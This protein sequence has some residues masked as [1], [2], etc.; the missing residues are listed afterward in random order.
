MLTKIFLRILHKIYIFIYPN[1]DI[2]GRNW[3]MFSHKEYANELIYQLLVNDKPAMIARFG[4]TEMICLVNYLGV[5]RQNTKWIDFIKDNSTQWWWDPKIINQMQVWSGFFPQDINKI[6]Q[7]CDLM[8]AD[9]EEVDILGSWLHDERHFEPSL[10]NAKRIVLE[11]LEPFFCANP[12]TRALEGKKVLVV[13][14]FAET[15]ENQYKNRDLIFDNH[16][17]PAFELKTIKAVQSVAGA[18]TEFADWFEA[19][20]S[21]KSQIDKTDYD[22]CIIGCGAYGFPLAA[23]V[24]RSGKKA[25]HMAGVTQLLFGIKGK[26]WEQ[27]IVWPYMNLFNEHWVRPGENEKPKGANK[28]EGACYW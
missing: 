7:F 9:M 25:I 22:I 2:S 13:H 15:I 26:R 27:F 4:S 17:L 14:P 8:L 5:K 20:E 10:T 24:K 18:E 23:H 16:L 3:K 28:V 11:D 12:W 19:L 1:K 6:E 21:M